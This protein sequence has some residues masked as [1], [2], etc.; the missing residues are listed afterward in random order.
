M[1][2]RKSIFGLGAAA[3]LALAGYAIAGVGGGQSDRSDPPALT[4]VQSAVPTVLIAPPAAKARPSLISRIR[5]PQGHPAVA[6]A[7]IDLDCG[8]ATYTVSSG[9][10]AGACSTWTTDGV[11]YVNCGSTEGQSAAN[12]AVGCASTSGSGSCARKAP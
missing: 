12:C 10:N 9:D 6:K 3:G 7:S 11:K 1:I 5:L 4:S 2:D 8:A